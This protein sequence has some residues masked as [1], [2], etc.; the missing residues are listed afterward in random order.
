[1]I[2]TG[3]GE[4]LK[5]FVDLEMASSYSDPILGKLPMCLRNVSWLNKVYG[6]YNRLTDSRVISI[7][8]HQNSPLVSWLVSRSMAK[9]F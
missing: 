6:L 9:C 1:M 5:G 8:A 4:A 7:N 3:L 2:L